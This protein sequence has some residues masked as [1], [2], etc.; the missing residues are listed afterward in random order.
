MT[1][2]EFKQMKTDEQAQTTWDCGVMVGDRVQGDRHMILYR[3]EAFYVEIQ[4]DSK[5]NE[6]AAIVSF[7][8]D[9]PLQP[10][11][12]KIDLSSLL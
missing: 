11:L 4:Y 12:D 2:Y 1:L 3:M 10:Y 5:Q 8:S 7:T 9:E 6:I